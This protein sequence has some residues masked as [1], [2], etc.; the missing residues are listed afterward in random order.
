MSLRPTSPYLPFLLR[1]S[2]QHSDERRQCLCLGRSGRSH[3]LICCGGYGGEVARDAVHLADPFRVA[4]LHRLKFECGCVHRFA[5]ARGAG[6]A[7]R[8]D[9]CRGDAVSSAVV[10]ACF[11]WISGGRHRRR[12]LRPSSDRL[13]QVVG[14]GISLRGGEPHHQV[15]RR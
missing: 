12:R 13:S 7:G 14:E 9:A 15:K 10:A 3:L 4:A 1:R 6:T 8:G 5:V 2:V 11:G